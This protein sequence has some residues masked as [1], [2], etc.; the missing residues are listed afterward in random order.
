MSEETPAR[1]TRI[2][3]FTIGFA[4]K[5]AR[6]FFARLREAGV[7]KVVDIRL[8]N[9]SQLA[10]FTK[11]DDLAYFLEAI[12]GIDYEHRPELAPTKE[13]LDGYKKKR[14]TWAEYEERFCKLMTERQIERLLTPGDLNQAC[15]L[16][17]EPT[18][19]KCH[20]RLV[21]EYLKYRW[22][23]CNADGDVYFHWRVMLLPPN[24]VRYLLLHELVH[25]HEHNHSPAFYMHLGRAVPE[26][27][28]IEAWL[29]AN[30]DS[31]VL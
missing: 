12:D 14:L 28:E 8:N 16:C 10:G 15:L 1:Q 23:S 6:G 30:G 2:T 26:H 4:K 18:A 11:R 27:R 24:V 31:Y 13:I 22:G 3:L 5:S 9:V 29:E 7:K 19:D 17:S 25:L 21:A 20:R